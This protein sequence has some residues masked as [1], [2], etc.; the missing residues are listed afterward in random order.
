MSDPIRVLIADDHPFIRQGIRT[1]LAGAG[2]IIVVGEAV[3]GHQVQR[4]CRELRPDVV[5]LDLSMPGASAYETVMHLRMRCPATRV[6]VL[7]AYDDDV[8]VR[9]MLRT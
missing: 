6:L 2:D 1:T 7:S 5:L 4:L 9:S 8:Y 3:D